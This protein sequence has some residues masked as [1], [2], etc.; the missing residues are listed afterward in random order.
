VCLD[1]LLLVKK[2]LIEVTLEMR[3]LAM[4]FT[5]QEPRLVKKNKS[6]DNFIDSEITP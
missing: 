3:I 2:A 4:D 5:K 6:L 1:P